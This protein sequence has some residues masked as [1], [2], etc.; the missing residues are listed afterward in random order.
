MARARKS[1]KEKLLEK[2][3]EVQDAIEK[4]EECLGHMREEKNAYEK[5]LKALEADELMG[6]MNERNLSVDDIK[7]IVEEN[8]QALSA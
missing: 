8:G 3:Q 4:Y 7:R 6:F 5:E 1:N 2:L